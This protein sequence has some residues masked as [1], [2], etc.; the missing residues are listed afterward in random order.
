ME[1]LV[2]HLENLRSQV[3]ESLGAVL[4]QHALHHAKDDDLTAAIALVGDIARLA[5]GLLIEGVGEL[6]ERSGGRDVDTRLTTRQGCHNL[7]ELVRRLML[8]SSQTAGRLERAQ[9]AVAPMWDALTDEE[10]PAPL[11]ALRAALLSGEVGIDGV[12]A[13]GPTLLEM[14][15]RV[16]VE[17]VLLA[18]EVLAAH[19]RG[20]GPDSAP[21]VDADV[22]RVHAQVWAIA[23]DQDGSEPH[24]RDI[25]PR[26]GV[27]LGR[28]RHGLIP[29]TGGLLPEVAAQL[30]MII[31]A[32]VGSPASSVRFVDS[33]QPTA[34]DSEDHPRDDRTRAQ[35]AHDALA[36]ALSVA[37]RSGDLPT[38]GGAA[39]TLVVS[40]RAEDLTADTGWATVEG[41][42][43]PVSMTVA[44]HVGC[45]GVVQRVA[46]NHEGRILRLGTEERLF[47]RHQRRA[48][49][50]R[51]GGC[52]IPGCGVPAGWCEVHH[53]TEH[54]QGGPT[55]SDN[56]VLLCWWHH[57]F[58]DTG[59][60]RIRMNRGVPEVQAPRW[61][62]HTLRWR[63]VT[64][65]RVRMLDLVGRR[66]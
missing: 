52:L 10:R 1:A 35:K 38:I 28:S 26:R 37:A 3:A 47:N 30:Q 19:A 15:D 42:D 32:T 2:E 63:P 60:W 45:S 55:H 4:Q 34:D 16:S 13:V 31:D 24:D 9:R 53:V 57:R 21:P 40:V 8:C 62:D 65:S 36:L 66:T 5:E 54:S 51:D 48:I 11:P 33:D 64:R 44:R 12:L 39:P 43:E 27:S 59:P 14:R 49:A 22:L 56:G 7:N 61:F 25:T 29:I 50:V 58:I 18:D 46:L 6:A 41:T 17:K 23:L 20:E